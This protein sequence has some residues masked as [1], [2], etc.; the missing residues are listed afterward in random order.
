MKIQIIIATGALAVISLVF[1]V[2]WFQ[3]HMRYE[4]YSKTEYENYIKAYGTDMSALSEKRLAEAGEVSEKNLAMTMC[5]NRYRKENH[6]FAPA[7]TA[8]KQE[9]LYDLIR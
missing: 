1:V 7:L 6:S 2:P 3:N 4:N 5:L 9:L 8:C